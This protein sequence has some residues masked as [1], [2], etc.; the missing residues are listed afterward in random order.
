VNLL[1]RYIFRS[2]L[3]TALAAVAL[4]TF[5][6]AAGNI[7]RDLMG[8]LLSGQLP[9]G[10][11][12]R[13]VLLLIPFVTYY[14]LPLGMLTGVLLT[15]GRL[16]SDS[17]VTAMRAAGMSVVRI[18]RPAL[19]LAVLGVLVG[20]RVN[21]ESMPWAR[22]QYHKE[23]AI[24]V[25]TNPLSY[26][27][28]KTFIR[29]FPGY[30]IYV[31]SKDEGSTDGKGLKDVWIWQLDSAKRVIRFVRAE[32]GRVGYDEAT[33][34]FVISLNN[35]REEDHDQKAPESFAQPLLV[36]TVGQ[37][38]DIRLSLARYFGS[39][40]VNQKLPWMTYRELIAEKARVEQEPL[41]KGGERQRERDVLKVS[42]TIQDKI[43]MAVAIFSFAF[44]GVP[45][46]I[47]VSRR[48]TS[49]NLGVAVVLALAYYFLIVVVGWM[50]QHPE[51][52]PDILLWVPNLV[53]LSL[54]ALLLFRLD[55]A[56]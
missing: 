21:F 37:I 9:I 40:T 20:L 41:G 50:D 5:V 13:L 18:A 4:F 46:G 42:L 22:V 32:S 36:S 15:L 11:F 14:A 12:I 52:H 51:Y 16:S 10:S 6:L 44:I 33:N 35:T 19:I 23:L 54:G 45:L 55:R 17:E 43:N 27:R 56:S 2:V 26:I 28:P 31:G 29:E 48:E 34:D 38:Q 7:I 39:G 1:D 24:A 53:L 30:V 3:L 25:R 8:P 49:A 47:K